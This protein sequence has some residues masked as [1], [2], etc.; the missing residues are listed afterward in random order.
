LRTKEH[1]V[2]FARASA[3][4]RQLLH[5]IVQA[6]SESAFVRGEYDTAVFQAFKEFEIVVRTSAGLNESDF[7]TDLM[8]RAFN[9]T[10][11]PLTDTKLPVPERQALAH[12]CAGAI[13][14]YNNPH[15][16]RNVA[17]DAEQA[18]EMLILASHLIRIA[19]SRRPMP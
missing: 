11:G 19:E 4:P 12:L 3:F 18:T 16:H 5:S 6:K 7:G 13:G 17:I 1:V 8:R 10:S 14:S 2:A 9:E 15:S